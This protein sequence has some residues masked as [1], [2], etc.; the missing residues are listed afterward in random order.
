[1]LPNFIEI[2]EIIAEISRF[3]DIQDGGCD[4][5]DLKSGIFGCRGGG[6]V[7]KHITLPNSVEIGQSVADIS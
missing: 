5:H 2:A 7:S 4:R 6:T 3:F 1:M